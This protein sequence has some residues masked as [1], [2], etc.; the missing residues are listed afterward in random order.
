MAKRESRPTIRDVATL[1]EVSVGTVSNVLNNLATVKPAI[2]EKVRSAI[3]QLGFAPDAIAQ[4][5]RVGSTH[6]I[7]CILRDLTIPLLTDF[8]RAAHDTFDAAGFSLLI[9]NTEGRTEREH[10]LLANLARRR[11]DGV[12]I[13]P[14]TPITGE[15][16]EFLSELK[17]PVVLLDRSEASWLDAVMI[18]HRDGMFRA[19]KHLLGL[20]HRRIALITGDQRL[21]PSRERVA[22]FHEAFAE[23]GIV[24]DPDL[25]RTESFLPD[26]A[27]ETVTELLRRP[28]R[29]TAIIA[30]GMDMLSGV[31]RAVRSFG[32]VIPRDLSIFGSG[33]SELAQLHQPDIS[34]I[35]WDYAKVGHI[36]ANMLLDRIRGEVSTEVRH[37]IVPTRLVMRASVAPPPSEADEGGARRGSRPRRKSAV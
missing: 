22:G 20:G 37:I 24:P 6:M 30:G 31:L 17:F 32:L 10:V 2:R 25:I 13:G 28:D 16:R 11:V 12:I 27:S 15:F 8:I 14:Y 29:P 33:D 21:Y 3:A 1:A 18:H 36:A 5:M 23:E 34:M 19:V 4:S 9:S 26:A 35:D 7:G